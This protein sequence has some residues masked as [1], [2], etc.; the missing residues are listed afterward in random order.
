[1]PLPDLDPTRRFS[2]RTDDYVRF[3]PDYPAEA[4]DSVLETCPDPV[5]WAVADI[6]AGTGISARLLGD[7]GVHVFA[8]E[9]N[10]EMRSA[11][12]SHPN[13]EWIAGTGEDTGLRQG[14]VDLVLCAQAFHWL[15]QAE[16]IVEFHRILR[17]GGR[18]AIVW[19]RRD[20]EDPLTRGYIEAI[21]EVNGE[22][23]AERRDFDPDVVRGDGRF[24]PPRLRSFPHVQSL[25]RSGLVG[26]ARSASYVPKE[27]PGWERLV[28]LLDDLYE[29]YKDAKGRVIL[30]YRTEVWT[31]EAQPYDDRA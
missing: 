13:V 2:D 23:P 26:R 19:N 9:P 22:H 24:G 7:R 28:R 25:D 29:T 31:S 20:R 21:H 17:P 4:I 12:E 30:R 15:R 10:A 8:V 18:L 27:G 3:R 14:S 11:A 5:R 16:A 1:M 6:G